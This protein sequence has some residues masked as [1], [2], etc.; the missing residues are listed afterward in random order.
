MSGTTLIPARVKK[1]FNECYNTSSEPVLKNLCE[2]QVKQLSADDLND[3]YLLL[4]E[5]T[6]SNPEDRK[7]FH[8]Y[9]Y[10]IMS[11]VELSYLKLLEILSRIER[12]KLPFSL[13]NKFKDIHAKF[14]ADTKL[15]TLLEENEQIM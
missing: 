15:M 12:K 3:F 1:L 2:E 14:S 9:Y 5:K 4:E 13:G 8:I 6:L 10:C 7:C 11:D